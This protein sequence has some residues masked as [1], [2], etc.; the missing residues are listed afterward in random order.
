MNVR[1]QGMDQG[2]ED[3]IQDWNQDCK[4]IIPAAGHQTFCIKKT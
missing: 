2:F 1:L 3:F 4:S